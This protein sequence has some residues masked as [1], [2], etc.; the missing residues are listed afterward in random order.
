MRWERDCEKLTA[1]HK[2][3]DVPG[4]Q[5]WYVNPR[6]GVLQFT[7]ALPSNSSLNATSPGT[8]F[9]GQNVKGESDASYGNFRT[10]IGI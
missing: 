4:H 8:E 3:V 7:E 9:A 1:K 10:N 2:A 6:D 5:Y